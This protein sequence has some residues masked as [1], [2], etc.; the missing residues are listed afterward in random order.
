MLKIHYF[1]DTIWEDIVLYKKRADPAN[2]ILV[3]AY[4]DYSFLKANH[5]NY[6][7]KIPIFIKKSL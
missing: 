2:F 4:I 5:Y 7:P 3:C 1:S 6:I